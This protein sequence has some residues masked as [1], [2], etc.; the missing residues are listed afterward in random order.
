MKTIKD[1]N[2]ELVDKLTFEEYVDLY[3]E[4][5]KTLSE[6]SLYFAENREH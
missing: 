6:R 5:L 2:Q 4:M 1:L 3:F